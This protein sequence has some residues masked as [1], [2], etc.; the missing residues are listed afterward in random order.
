MLLICFGLEHL[1][2]SKFNIKFSLIKI[3]YM[4][5]ESNNCTITPALYFISLLNSHFFFFNLIFFA[6]VL[7][8]L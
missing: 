1:L 7:L 4:F 5:P 8:E 6:L 2:G 3:L